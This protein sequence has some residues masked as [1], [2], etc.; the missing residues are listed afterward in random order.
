MRKSFYPLFLILLLWGF[1]A[2]QAQQR[3][4][5]F[6]ENNQEFIEQLNSLLAN[7]DRQ[8]RQRAQAYLD[9]FA[10]VWQSETM[11]EN[12]RVWVRNTLNQ[13]LGMRLRPW[14]D[15]ALYLEGVV[16]VLRTQHA[17]RNFEV[18]HE[19]FQ[20]LMNTSQQRRLLA[21]WQKSVNLFDENLLF[22]AA[23]VNWRLRSPNYTLS[24]ER[25]VPEV[26]FQ[27]NDLL[28]FSQGDS[29]VILNTSARVNLLED[30]LTG[31]GGRVTWERVLL[32]PA[33]VYANFTN[34]EINLAVAR[35]EADT[36]TFYNLDF[37][38]EPLLGKFS[39]RLLA[40]VKPEDAR[41]PRFQSYQAVHEI[42]NLF[43]GI[44]FMGG[45]TMMGQRVL[46][47]GTDQANASL[48]FYRA[49]SL[50]ITAR[51]RAFVIRNDRI[52]SDRAAVSIYL[53]GDS[54][55]H[56]S[57]S[58][59]YLH[60]NREFSL[61]RDERG[62]SRAPFMNTFHQIDMY[63][64][65][66]YWNIETYDIE[67]RMIR[68]MSE[69]G[70]AS[71]ESHNF[72]S[73][74][75][76]MRM[77]GMSGLHPLIRIRNFSN[78]Y[79][80]RTFPV[81]ELAR[82]LRQDVASVTAQLLS[83]SFYGFVSYD[84]DTETVTLNDRLFHYITSYA[85]RSD[86]DVIQIHSEAP[87][88]ARLNMNNFDL[89]IMGV[90]RI[91]LSREKNVVLH[92]AGRQVVMKKNR[93]MYF[94]GR[95]ESGL[96][97]FYGRE[98]FFDYDNFKIELINT[99]SMAFSVRSFDADTRG[100]HS[101]V[102]V[103]TVLEG[104]NGELLVDHP[105]NKSGQLPYPRYPIFNSNNE[106]YV[107]YDREF[108]QK[109]AYKRE[110]VYF[111]LIPFSIDSL[112]NATT[113]NIAFDGV[114]IS[115]G[116]FPDFY[117]YLTVQP[118]YSLGFNTQT[119]ED[120]YTVYGGKAVYKGPIDMSYEGL[121]A[122]GRL[123][124]LNATL[125]ANQMLMFPDSARAQIN[126]FSLTA[127]AGP[128]EYP[129]VKARD[130]N[131]LYKPFED[132]MSISHTTRPFELY[133]GL[134]LLEGSID[135][136]PVGLGGNGK[137]TFFG[138]EMFAQDF[139]YKLNDFSSQ[140]SNLNLMEAVGRQP[141][142]R[143]TDYQAFVDVQG[144]SSQ[145]QSLEGESK[146][147]FVP[148][149]F[150]ALGFDFDWDMEQGTLS[151]ENTLRSEIASRGNIS[152]QEWI[153][154]N[155]KGNELISTH[156]AQDS[157]RFYAGRMEYALADNVIQAH[158]VKIIKVAD[159]A[160]YPHMER[161]DILPRAEIAKL[162]NA[163]ILANTWSL[164][165]RFY[166]AEVNI[167]TRW[168]YSGSGKYDFINET[169]QPQQIFFD[170]ISVDRAHRTTMA[171]AKIEEEHDFTISPRFGYKGDIE[172]RAENPDFFYKG[173]TQIFADCP[174]YNPNW[175]RFE[176]RVKAD[177]VYIPLAEDLRNDANGRIFSA[178]MLAGDSVHIYP[179]LFTR[180]RHY[181][182][183]EIAGAT[184]FLT[185]DRDLRQYQVSTAEKFR[186]P[187]LPDNIIT[188]NPAT[189]MVRASGD[190][191]LSK[192][193]GQFKI[194]TYG[195][196]AMDLHQK[197]VELDLVMGIDFFFLNTAL[198]RVESSLQAMVEPTAINLNRFKYTAH[199][200]KLTG[201]ETTRRLMEEVAL[202][203]SFRRFPPELAHTFFFADVKM[204]WDQDAQ[205]FYST[206]PIGIGNMDRFPLNRYVD[207]FIEL[208][209]HRS[210]DIFNMVLIPSGFA[211]EGIGTQWY[212]FTYT[213]GIMQ[214]I[215]SD[216]EFNNMVRNLKPNRRRQQVERGE[217]PFT[218]ILSSDRRPFDFVRAMRNLRQ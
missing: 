115:T 215:A 108:V 180:Q 64:E 125:D 188:L 197:T 120:G 43:P 47:S 210:G 12:Q 29:I 156:P 161:V 153:H 208:N 145:L 164:H 112:D 122:D 152:P 35:F 99:D 71:F 75:R 114:F 60:P 78:E 19:S 127:Q 15:Y 101:L 130:V 107:Y 90:E 172:L 49:D 171:Q 17:D 65:A 142:V 51:G 92:P 74:L 16:K 24:F 185:F 23:S 178:L 96:F 132:N 69:T 10:V 48:K 196:A 179:A 148:N 165:H 11:L 195:H 181:S 31:S 41:Y 82:F 84:A 202:T 128:V 40:E 25:G 100:R 18:W 163:Q 45:F 199:L 192:D 119:P 1:Q 110:D 55:Y 177:S 61:Q 216:T 37:F 155:F 217:Q 141:A 36:V 52:I 46:G 203:G 30:K 2:V 149:R 209:K 72:F 95:V 124:Y 76:Y 144:R 191:T 158:E 154:Y 160:V 206:E 27:G 103:R 116:I 140:R 121:R 190:V 3:L 139:S 91:P 189:C 218:F 88:N 67:M 166:D 117:D 77:Q 28:C 204:K 63:C 4:S 157:L 133:D 97:D 193:M 173:A 42:K 86:F 201:G 134:V 59:R 159:A 105:L 38:R 85:G 34:Y 113:D 70:Q 32:D 200:E 20:N 184:G 131:M 62:F 94:D 44:D 80:S 137:S 186:N 169:G 187:Q 212:F 102:R 205:T 5:S 143:A 147:A 194:K 138:G 39:E 73:D 50:F 26:V 98:F 81:N 58:L 56:P 214:T 68:G 118:D 151:L 126:T 22:S 87:I 135:L 109:G 33:R 66:I 174:D 54:I 170:R 104:I 93:D 168:S 89:H 176:A 150:D 198:A 129:S 6:S 167:A 162:E 83:F 123:E 8:E 53:S 211:D 183:L 21:Y 213:N 111:R 182:D 175:I 146:L 14:P 106:S 136:T 57:I 207:G 9:S 13:M 7:L 79:N